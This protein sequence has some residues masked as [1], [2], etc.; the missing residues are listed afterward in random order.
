MKLVSDFYTGESI[1]E[2]N[3]AGDHY[4]PRSLGVDAGGVTEYKNLV[5]CSKRMNIKKGQV[6]MVMIIVKMITLKDAA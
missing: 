5:V 3:I 6:C 1:A 4:I 2:D